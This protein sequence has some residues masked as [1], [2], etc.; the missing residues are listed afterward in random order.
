MLPEHAIRAMWLKQLWSGN[1]TGD[2]EIWFKRSSIGGTYTRSSYSYFWQVT[3]VM[4]F[5]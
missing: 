5:Q 2:D 1:G 4:Q 3:C